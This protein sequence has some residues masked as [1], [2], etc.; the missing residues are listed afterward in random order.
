MVSIT[1]VFLSSCSKKEYYWVSIL[2]ASS[3]PNT[4]T[5]DTTILSSH[6]GLSGKKEVEDRCPDSTTTSVNSQGD[7][8]TIRG[9]HYSK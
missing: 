2:V 3:N 7:T 5:P 9:L 1:L 8:V 6:W 4:V